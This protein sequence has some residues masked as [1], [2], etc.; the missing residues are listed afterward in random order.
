MEM[1]RWVL[2][3]EHPNSLKSMGN[4]TLIYLS[5]GWWKEAEDLQ[6]LAMETRKQVLGEEHPDWLRN[7]GNLMSM[8]QNQG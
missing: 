1:M 6:V 8:Y 2:S 7:M 4:L 5:R 3:I